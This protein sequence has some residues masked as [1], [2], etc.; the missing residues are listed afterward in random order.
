MG[1]TEL[2]GNIFTTHTFLTHSLTDKSSYFEFHNP[3]GKYGSYLLMS[4]PMV[5]KP[6]GDSIEVLEVVVVVVDSK[7][8][9]T[10]GRH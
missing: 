8:I 6:I 7:Y 3:C 4:S 5:S 9:L 1:R 10:H 2:I